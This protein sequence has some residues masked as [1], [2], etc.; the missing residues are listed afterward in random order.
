MCELQDGRRLPADEVVWCTDAGAA[1]WVAQS[2]LACDPKGFMLLHATLE[3]LSHA[4]A[5][6]G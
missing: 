2:G 5:F 3:S 4:G 1:P 6:P